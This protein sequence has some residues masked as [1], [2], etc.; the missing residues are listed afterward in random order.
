MQKIAEKAAQLQRA[1]DEFRDQQ[2]RIDGP[3]HSQGKQ[4]LR[5]G[6]KALE[7]DLN[8]RLAT[9][10]GIASS[11]KKAY[12]KWLKSHQPF[13]WL[14]D[15]VRSWHTAPSFGLGPSSN[16]DAPTAGESRNC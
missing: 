13:H 12:E 5:E 1:F 7:E 2:V 15:T 3:I 4:Q 16:A 11:N 10:H 6:L 14:V 8:V 9:E